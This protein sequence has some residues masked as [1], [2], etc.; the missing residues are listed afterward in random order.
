MEATDHIDQCQKDKLL[1]V[2]TILVCALINLPIPHRTILVPSWNWFDNQ[3]SVWPGKKNWTIK[4][5]VVIKTKINWPPTLNLLSSLLAEGSPKITVN[6]TACVEC[7]N[8]SFWNDGVHFLLTLKVSSTWAVCI[9]NLYVSGIRKACLRLAL[10]AFS[11]SALAEL[12]C[13]FNPV[14]IHCAVY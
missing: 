12:A 10:H 4:R 6:F 14:L 2:L 5:N 11:P 13:F 8:P 7:A 3:W 9:F 1:W